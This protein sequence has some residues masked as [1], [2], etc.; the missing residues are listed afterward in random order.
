MHSM[1]RRSFVGMAL[2]A[3]PSLTLAACGSNSSAAST[4]S[5]TNSATDEGSNG[6]VEDGKI[7]N[8]VLVSP[9]NE[10]YSSGLHHATIEVKNYGTIELE[11]NADNTPI[12]VSNF[13]H[14]VN[15]GFYDGLT[16]HRIIKDFMVQ[17][18]DPKGN[19]TG[20]SDVNIKGEF[21]ANGIVNAIQHKRGVISM[22]RSNANDSASSQFFIMHADSSQLDGQYAAFGK[23]TS[24]LEV[25]DKLV[26]VKVEDS[27]GTVAA[28]N[29]PIITSIKMVD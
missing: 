3:I 7:Q 2:L 15:A 5:S 4:A 20:G 13:A 28:E 10:G 26:E 18:G 12:T 23:V 14:L 25:I 22:A 17:G 16:F 29:Q 21:S 8:G 9:Y 24:G 27:N 19:G 11:L 1:N 6:V